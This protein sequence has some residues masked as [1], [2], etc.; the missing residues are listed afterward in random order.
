M[1]HFFFFKYQ[2]QRFTDENLPED[3]TIY[4][5]VNDGDGT[6]V[7]AVAEDGQEYH[8][9]NEESM[10]QDN[11]EWDASN[12]NEDQLQ[13]QQQQLQQEEEPQV[14]FHHVIVSAT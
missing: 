10:E 13:Q 11:Q 4:Y 14:C 8:Y 2:V 12:Q 3:G 6:Y 7:Q 1:Q 5:A 9:A